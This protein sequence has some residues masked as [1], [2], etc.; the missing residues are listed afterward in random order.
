L[1]FGFASNRLAGIDGVSL[2]TIKWATVLQYYAGGTEAEGS[3]SKRVPE[4]HFCYPEAMALS[5]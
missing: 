5:E 2:L 1:N 3:P 4:M